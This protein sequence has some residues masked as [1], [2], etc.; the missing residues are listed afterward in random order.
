MFKV[1]LWVGVVM[2]AEQSVY[3]LKAKGI[4]VAR[5]RIVQNGS[6]KEMPMVMRMVGTS[7]QGPARRH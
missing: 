4:S 3:I 2:A 5:K 1:R 6:Q 7:Q